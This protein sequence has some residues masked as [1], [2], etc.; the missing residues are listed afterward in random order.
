MP[1]AAPKL[2][3]F[4]PWRDHRKANVPP[5]PQLDYVARKIVLMKPMC[6]DDDFPH[7]RIIQAR[8]H[9]RVERAVHSLDLSEIIAIRDVEWVIVDDDITAAPSQGSA[10]RRCIYSAALGCREVLHFCAVLCDARFENR[11]VPGKLQDLPDAVGD[12]LGQVVGV[13]NNEDLC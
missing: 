4:L 12:V 6:N 10:C 1:G 3:G 5:T 11:L 7:L 13:C 9:H 2:E 8:H